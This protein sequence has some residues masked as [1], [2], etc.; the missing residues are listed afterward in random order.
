MAALEVTTCDEA[1]GADAMG[2]IE[3]MAHEPVGDGEP[4]QFPSGAWFFRCLHGC[5]LA[6]AGA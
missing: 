3:G 4:G 6:L 2:E 5:T 1:A